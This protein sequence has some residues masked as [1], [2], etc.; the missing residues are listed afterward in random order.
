MEMFFLRLLSLILSL[1]MF[2]FN[3][4]SSIFPGLFPE[5]PI[6][7]TAIVCEA[8]AFED[9]ESVTKNVIS[10]YI[11]WIEAA[12]E[13]TEGFEEFNWKYFFTGSMALVKVE[14]PNPDCTVEIE[15]VSEN[16]ST[17]ELEY[18]IIYPEE[19]STDVL[20]TK[21]ILVKVSKNISEIDASGELIMPEEPVTPDIPEIPEEP[22][23]PEE[24]VDP[25]TPEEPEI[26]NGYK[27][28]ICDVDLF[29]DSWS[30]YY[31]PVAEDFSD[32]DSW[33]EY[34]VGSDARLNVY[35]AAYFEEKSLAVF[36]INIPYGN[37]DITVRSIESDTNNRVDVTFSVTDSEEECLTK[38]TAVV[39]E[40]AKNELSGYSFVLGFMEEAIVADSECFKSFTKIDGNV[41]IISSLTEWTASLNYRRSFNEEYNYRF[42]NEFFEEKSIALITVMVPTRDYKVE[43]EPLIKSEDFVEISYKVSEDE[44]VFYDD[45]TLVHY[46]IIAAEIPKGAQVKITESG[47]KNS[48]K[49]YEPEYL[50][51][52]GCPKIISD[53]EAWQNTV[54]TDSSD[55]ARYDESYFENH[56]LVLVYELFAS[57]SLDFDMK[58][59]FENGD[60]L[61]V[62]YSEQEFDGGV[63]AIVVGR[64]ALIEVTKNIRNV[65]VSKKNIEN[66]YKSFTKYGNFN[67]SDMSGDNSVISDYETWKTYLNSTTTGV[68]K[69]NEK[70]FEENSLALVVLTYPDGTIGSEIAYVYEEG[71]IL[72]FGYNECYI[73]ELGATMP[74]SEVVLVEVSKDITQIQV[75]ELE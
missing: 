44:D 66:E 58:K 30:G 24:P 38:S 52:T 17:L 70:Y 35:D 56:S 23:E 63:L 41:E 25:E 49:S 19:V 73:A 55:F 6:E 72:Q 74:Y 34:Y 40:I 33:K 47:F 7:N 8:E 2:L 64:V 27:Y 46:I 16:G 36:F 15:S 53:Y 50:D 42:T 22:E 5:K 28:I 65:S 60:T 54:L 9:S 12:E 29:N 3:T 62:I 48:F 67:L 69:Y 45:S 1:L 75:T 18:N 32:Y 39:V 14:L 21:I 4:F 43:V 26:L 57:P 71:N 59:L 13:N 61:E 51:A 37:K 68:D 20:E 11:S 10:D 31:S